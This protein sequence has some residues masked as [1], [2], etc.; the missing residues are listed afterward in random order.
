MHVHLPKPLHGWRAL[1][2]EVGII[3]VG[4][5]IALGAEQ[6]VETIHHRSE[7]REAEDAMVKELRDDDLPQAFTRT[8]IYHCYAGQLDALQHAVASGDRTKVLALA[9]AY[10]PI[11]RT[12]DEQAWE[13]AVSS[14]VLVPSGSKRLLGWSQSYVM[15]PSLGQ[16]NRDE[17]SELAEL[18][19]S[20]SGEGRLS[21]AQQDR[22]YQVISRL[23]RDNRSMTGQSLVFIRY[24]DAQGLRLTPAQEAA[25]LAEVRKTYGTCVEP[26]SS[27]QLDMKAQIG[28]QWH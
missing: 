26:V 11:D 1:V 22:L 24:L 25:L 28:K 7:L 27:G 20:L 19:A 21:G 14:Q 8:A 15:I 13:A 5:L 23:R 9:A 10:R 17:G 4:V 18:E 3:V 2:G 16:T 6:I 12:W